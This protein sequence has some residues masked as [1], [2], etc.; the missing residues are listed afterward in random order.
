MKEI[1]LKTPSYEGS[2]WIGE[3]SLERI[4]VLTQDQKNF[5]VTDENVY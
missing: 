2:I 4:P 3:E 5:V 1:K